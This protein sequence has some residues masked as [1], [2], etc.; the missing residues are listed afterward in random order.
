MNRCD[1][2]S[3][4]IAFIIIF[5][6]TLFKVDGIGSLSIAQT[7][8][9]SERRVDVQP[10]NHT[11][12][13]S[14]RMENY[15]FRDPHT[16][17]RVNSR[18]NQFAIDTHRNVISFT[19]RDVGPTESANKTLYVI[20]AG[21]ESYQVFFRYGYSGN[22][23]VV[24]QREHVS[25]P[26]NSIFSSIRGIVNAPAGGVMTPAWNLGTRSWRN[27]AFV[28]LHYRGSIPESIGITL[29]AI[30][31]DKYSRTLNELTQ[32]AVGQISVLMRFLGESTYY[33][34]SFT[35][36]EIELPQ[37]GSGSDFM[38]T[39]NS[40]PMNADRNRAIQNEFGQGYRVADWN[41]LKRFHQNGGDIQ[42]LFREIGV[43]INESVF[44]TLNSRTHYSTTRAY[45]ASFHQQRKPQNYLAHDQIN[46]NM[47]SLGSWDGNRRILVIRR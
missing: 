37:E 3:F 26:S 10:V 19:I 42:S 32:V 5:V 23:Q 16:L 38:V 22:P 7:I 24:R 18:G 28:E 12:L 20:A 15:R 29:L 9:P 33:H 4:K 1:L 39:R 2:I 25:M 13:S 47:V 17:A 8:S 44:V 6:L 45:F 27:D 14:S 41:D 36:Y 40:Y 46:R 30:N 35:T 11:I 43:N 34:T 31:P 21:L